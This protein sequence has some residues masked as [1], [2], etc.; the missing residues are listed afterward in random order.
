MKIYFKGRGDCLKGIYPRFDISIFRIGYY[1]GKGG[2]LI[3]TFPDILGVKQPL[4]L[5]N[6]QT[7]LTSC[8]NWAPSFNLDIPVDW[9]SGI[10]LAK[11][12]QKDTGGENYIIFAVR[13]DSSHSDILYQQSVTTYQAY[14]NDGGKSLYSD[15]SNECSTVSDAERAI[16]VSF[17]RPYD[18]PMGD[19]ST[20]FRAEYPMVRWLEAQGYWVTYSTDL[21]TDHS[22]RSGA[23]NA[24]LDHKVFLSVGHDEYWSKEMRNAVTEAR[25]AGVNIGIFSGNT[26]FWDI[27]FTADPWSGKTDQTMVAYKTIESGGPDPSGIPT[28]SWRDPEGAGQPENAL[29]GVQYIGD[30]ETNFFPLRVYAD[31]VSDPLFRNTGLEQIPAG[32]YVDIGKN[33]VGWEWDGR[34]ENGDSPNGIIVLSDSPVFGELIQDAGRNFLLSTA[35]AQAT[36]Y[37]ASSGSIVFNSGTIQWSWGLDLYEPDFRIQQI[38]YNVFNLMGV[39]PATPAP[40]LIVSEP[41]ENHVT[42]ESSHK[43]LVPEYPTHPPIISDIAT[44]LSQPNQVT[45]TWHTDEPSTS[46]MWYWN[47]NPDGYL[48]NRSAWNIPVDLSQMVLVQAH[49]LDLTGVT[50]GS[51]YQFKLVSQDEH[52][53]VSLSAPQTI[54]IPPDSLINR[55]VT[56]IQSMMS[57]EICEAKP[58]VAPGFNW[59]KQINGWILSGLV[60]I[61]FLILGIWILNHRGLA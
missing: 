33:L 27:R 49:R 12:V 38:T 52:G 60:S 15:N 17:D 47:A 14:N 51:D 48:N 37:R 35:R 28:S 56:G 22:G 31:Q 57:N 8:S 21:D 59:L 55:I 43:H 13:D 11:L 19:P 26:S 3:E 18:A 44:D 32:S 61:V 36:Y 45:I 6:Y 1:A 9:V 24:L 50:P 10:Y 2:R 30:N 16:E 42:P 7:G 5:T 46:Q 39:Q 25:D 29:L 4:C 20:F 53:N 41:D 34:V 23:H 58:Y 40:D 54:E